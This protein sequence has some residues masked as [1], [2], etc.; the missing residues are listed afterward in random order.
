MGG[1]SDEELPSFMQES[2]IPVIDELN[3]IAQGAVDIGQAGDEEEFWRGADKLASGMLSLSGVPYD[4]V[5]KQLEGM[6]DAAQG[7]SDNPL[8][9]FL[10]FSEYAIFEEND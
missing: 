2:S 10:G 4:P 5:S 7:E 9:R 8:L 6:V 3:S 1:L